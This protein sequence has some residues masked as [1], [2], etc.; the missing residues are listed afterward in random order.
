MRIDVAQCV[1]HDQ[2]M[3]MV[4]LLFNPDYEN[5]KA[6]YLDDIPNQLKKS[7]AVLGT[8]NFIA[9]DKISF[10][11]FMLLEMLDRFE[12]LSPGCVSSVPSLQ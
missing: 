9:G 5:A 12:L 8:G 2:V 1:L 6:S 10:A 3:G 11:D 4:K 7:A